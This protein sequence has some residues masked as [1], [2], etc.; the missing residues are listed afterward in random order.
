VKALERAATRRRGEA[1]RRG[2][3]EERHG[4]D[5]REPRGPET[6]GIGEKAHDIVT[7]GVVIDTG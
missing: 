4:V 7:V 3:E 5:R 1:K 6:H 2:S